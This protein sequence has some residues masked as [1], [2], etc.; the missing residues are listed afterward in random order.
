MSSS[1]G[2]PLYDD[3]RGY[4]LKNWPNKTSLTRLGC[5]YINT[6]CVVAAKIFEK[7]SLFSEKLATEAMFSMVVLSIPLRMIGIHQAFSEKKY[8]ATALHVI[9][10]SLLFFPYGPVLSIGA[11][12]ISEMHA[13]YK[14]VIGNSKKSLIQRVDPTILSNAYNILAI[15]E[16]KQ[17][18]PTFIKGSHDHMVDTLSKIS[19][20][21][22]GRIKDSVEMKI[23]DIKDAY[24]TLEEHLKKHEK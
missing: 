9:A 21:V 6:A 5:V 2:F 1:L 20:D 3:P 4:R 8:F 12:C 23:Q 7:K 13:V 19:A 14:D 10:F 18:D 15:P 11:D 24:T 16:E 17:N 22:H